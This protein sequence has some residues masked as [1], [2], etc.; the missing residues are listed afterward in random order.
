MDRTLTVTGKY[1]FMLGIMP[2]YAGLYDREHSLHRSDDG[3]QRIFQQDVREIDYAAT[4]S[5]YPWGVDEDNDRYAVGTLVGTSLRN[6]GQ[7]WYLGLG[8]STPLNIGF[9]GGAG[10]IVVN[11]LDHDFEVGQPLADSSF[12]THRT[13]VPT[14]FLGVNIEAELFKRAFKGIVGD[15]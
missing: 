10:L 7:R 4:L 6:P 1:Y 8:L 3:V 12:P 5:A 14:W 15:D 11:E 2:T 13:V 9:V